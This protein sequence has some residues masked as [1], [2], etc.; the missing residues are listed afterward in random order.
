MKKSLAAAAFA[1][2]TF[3]LLALYPT[4]LFAQSDTSDQDAST[5]D[6]SSVAESGSK[7]ADFAPKGWK[8]EEDVK[9]DL[10]GDGIVD[11]CIKLIEDKPGNT[12]D[13]MNDRSRALVVVFGRQD[14]GLVKA[15][16][17]GKLLQCTGCGGAFYGVSDAP[18]NVKIEKGVIIVEQDHGSRWVTETTLRFRYD[19]QPGMFILIGYDY[20][21]RDRADG[22]SSSESTNY[23]NGK[24]ITTVAKGKRSTTKTTTV[25][26]D[27][28]SIEEVDSEEMDA[29]ATHR[30]GLD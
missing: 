12:E 11:H 10:N 2:L 22:S 21:S 30:L 6:P 13:T 17:A 8:V 25:A 1:F 15:A 29:A 14:G 4:S 19:E 28:M 27:R 18:A 3:S 26:K 24:R 9:G 23:L 20:A 16:V 7:P 5:I